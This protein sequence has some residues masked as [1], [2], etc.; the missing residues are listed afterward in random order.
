VDD[1]L[2]GGIEKREIVVVDYDPRWPEKFQQHAAILALALGNKAL[3]IEHVGSTSVP[4]LAA[5]PIID[6]DVLVED[7]SNEAVYLP[8]LVQAGYV[9]RVREP[10]WHEHRMFRTPELDVHVHLFAEGC[11]EFAR[12]IAFRDR[13]RSNAADRRLYESVKRKLAQEEWPDMNAYA[14]AKTEVVEQIIARASPNSRAI[15][16]RLWS[17]PLADGSI[18]FVRMQQLWDMAEGLP[19]RKVRVTQLNAL[20]DVRWFSELMG[21]QP[22]CRA[23][24]EHAR[25]IYE[26]DFRFPI[27][28]SP[29]GAV[30]DGMHRLCKAF[31]EG[32]EEIEAVQLAAMPP[33][34]WRLLSTGEEVA[35]VEDSTQ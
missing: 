6:I 9:L 27:I 32:I 7:P 20:D 23:V 12:H 3:A 1:I 14:R 30:L 11:V 22:T 2:I 25:D 35:I 5:K 10:D 26:A 4:A 24:A 21:K 28:L 8:A 29:S 15:S 33:A 17:T 19:S 34:L 16:K 13:L 31:L 18:P